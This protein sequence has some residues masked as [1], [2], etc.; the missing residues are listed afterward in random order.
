[1]NETIDVSAV[2][3]V[4]SRY[5]RTGKLAAEYLA[6][7]K[8]SG[9]SFELI[10]VLD[11]EREKIVPALIGLAKENPQVRIFRGF[12]ARKREGD[13]H[14]ASLLPGGAS[15]NWRFSRVA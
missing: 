1:M 13:T 3:T 12:R 7:L 2:V 15:G 8:Q 4:G 14:L 5:D 11:G 9:K 10:F 6:V